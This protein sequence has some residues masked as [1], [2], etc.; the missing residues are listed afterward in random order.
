MMICN[1]NLKTMAQHYGVSLPRVPPP[2]R[3]SG[4]QSALQSAPSRPIIVTRK[5]KHTHTVVGFVSFVFVSQ[6]HLLDAFVP[7]L[8]WQVYACVLF[9]YQETA[10]LLDVKKSFRHLVV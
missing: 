2:S 7:S 5:R 8:S 3:T 10:F 9:R 1:E 6:V 4:I